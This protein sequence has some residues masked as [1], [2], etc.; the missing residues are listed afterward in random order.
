MGLF[1]KS[2]ARHQDDL[3]ELK[4][5]EDGLYIDYNEP[6]VLAAQCIPKMHDL[7]SEQCI[8]VL[9]GLLK[10]RP[11]ITR[12][13]W[14]FTQDKTEKQIRIPGV[15]TLLH[16]PRNEIATTLYNV[17]VMND[18]IVGID[19]EP[20]KDYITAWMGVRPTELVSTI[21]ITS[22]PYSY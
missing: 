12:F 15:R 5:L 8:L 6:E 3:V 21:E 2:A 4:K 1:N 20:G 22:T 9:E 16:K 7:P 19:W 13:V 11:I 18:S 10:S 14:Y 17:F